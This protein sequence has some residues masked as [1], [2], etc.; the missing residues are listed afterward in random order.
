MANIDYFW[1]KATEYTQRAAK[2]TTD[3]ELRTF[4]SRLRDAWIAAANRA[5]MI[6]GLVPMRAGTENPD[7][8]PRHLARPSP[9]LPVLLHSTGSVPADH[10]S[11]S[12]DYTQ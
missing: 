1:R 9:W 8:G 4:F 7:D 5:E 3:E 2:E 11:T 10:N 12:A 6:E